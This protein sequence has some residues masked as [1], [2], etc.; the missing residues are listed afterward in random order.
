MEPIKP[1]VDERKASAILGVAVQT[2][3][4]WRHQRKGPPY[5]KISRSIRY[6]LDDLQEYKNRCRI[7]PEGRS[8]G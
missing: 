2:L 8:L 3:R 4:N 6:D 1:V 5:L 7:D